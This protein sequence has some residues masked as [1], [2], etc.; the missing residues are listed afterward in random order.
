MLEKSPLDSKEIQLVNP[1]GKKAWTF[2]GRIDA[3][4]E[5][6]ILWPP[7]GKSQLTGK[8]PD[9]GKD[10]EQEENGVRDDEMIRWHHWLNGHEFKQTPGDS[11]EQGSLLCCSS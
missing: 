7:D 3:K 1:K 2:I 5:S 10:W 4:A 8:D 6:S 9:A 11:E